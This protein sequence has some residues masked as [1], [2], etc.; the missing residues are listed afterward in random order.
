M[1]IV[2]DVPSG[3]PSPSWLSALSWSAIQDNIT[4]ALTIALIGYVE[5]IA[6]AKKYA[7]NLEYSF[8]FRN[9]NNLLLFVG[10]E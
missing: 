1:S 7:G 6:V 5:S 9:L 3:L 2:G 8:E 10:Y 4:D